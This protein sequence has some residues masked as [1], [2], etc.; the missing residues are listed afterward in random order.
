[1]PVK[2]RKAI[3]RQEILEHPDITNG[4]QEQTESAVE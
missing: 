3:E 1:L 2:A 4:K